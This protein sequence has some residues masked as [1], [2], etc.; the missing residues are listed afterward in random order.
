MQKRY[1][2]QSEHVKKLHASPINNGKQKC[3]NTKPPNIPS[4]VEKKPTSVK[5][6]AAAT[7]IRWRNV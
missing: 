7:L 2:F 4:R 1:C 5:T 6:D 3:F